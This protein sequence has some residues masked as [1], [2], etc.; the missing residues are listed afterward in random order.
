MVTYEA[1]YALSED[2]LLRQKVE[3]VVS[4][5]GQGCSLKVASAIWFEV[6]ALSHYLYSNAYYFS[7]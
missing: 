4:Y 1:R 7:L 5:R 3:F 6:S 2:K